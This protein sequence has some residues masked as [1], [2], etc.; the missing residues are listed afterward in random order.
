MIAV[1]KREFGSYFKTPIGYIAMALLFFFSGYFFYGN[2]LIGGSASLAGVYSWLFY[3]TMIVAPLLTMRAFSEEKRQRTDQALL[4]A[5]VSLTSIVVGKF[6]AA[7]ALF[8]LILTITLVYA[9]V[10][11]TQVTPDWMVIFGN[12]FGL[13][14]LSGMI[15]AAGVFFSSLT[16]SQFIAV[17]VTIAFAVGLLAIDSIALLFTFNDTLYDAV[18]FFS[19]YT[20][21]NTFTQG[22]ISYDNVF[23][24]LSLQGLFLFLT[25]RTLDAKRWN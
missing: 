20:R 1:F 11:A 4:T 10:I 17:I 14:L 22:I 13:M 7:I 6:L 21:Y 18:S 16:E 8:A 19:V 24:F 2:N 5:P 15:I 23:F 12:Y 9:I 3:V 25:V